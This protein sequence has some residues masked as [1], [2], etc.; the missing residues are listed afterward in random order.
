V[1]GPGR[2]EILVDGAPSEDVG[3]W[4]FYQKRESR[5]RVGMLLVLLF[6]LGEPR[7]FPYVTQESRARGCSRESFVRAQGELL[8]ELGAINPYSAS[9]CQ[10]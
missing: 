7:R 2:R 5:G 4:K 9:L 1:E 6:N 3:T 10:I 8:A